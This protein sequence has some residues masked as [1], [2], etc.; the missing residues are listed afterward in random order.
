MCVSPIS[1]KRKYGNKVRIDV[2]PCGKCPECLK[3]QQNGY[4]VRCIEE[5]RKTGKMWFITLT[6]NNDSV[7]KREFVDCDTGEVVLVNSLN[8]A[9]IKK[10]KREVRRSFIKDYGRSFP[11]F[12]FLICG[13][14]GPR[15]FRQHPHYHGVIFG[16]D[17]PYIDYL[18]KYWNE[19]Y[20]FSVFKSV[21][22]V[23]NEGRDN[24]TCV[25]RYVSKYCVKPQDLENPL[26]KDGIVE[27][28]RK[29]TSI[30][31]GLPDNFDEMSQY[32]RLNHDLSSYHIS[33]AQAKII[34]ERCKYVYNGQKYSLP[35]YY[36]KKIFYENGIN[37]NL[38][39][40]PLAK[41]CST[42]S[43]VYSI[44]DL[45]R[46]FQKLVSGKSERE[47]TKM[48]SKFIEGEENSLRSR[49]NVANEALKRAYKSSKF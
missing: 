34:N 43:R 33:P 17:K 20:G 27:K 7:P 38:V 35:L 6:Y 26:V 39:S 31:F 13:E 36:R 46:K 42:T 44:E 22:V 9:D 16:L 41:V 15:T 49:Y 45:N 40:S 23:S 11:T 8:R 28:P 47:A 25:A 14:Y 30:G 48:V 4:V 19:Y 3:K 5:A 12:S 18:E 1:I 32:I 37:Q 21:S 24:L 29:L 2:V 10:W